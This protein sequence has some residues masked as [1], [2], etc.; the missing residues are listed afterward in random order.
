MTKLFAT[1]NT[2]NPAGLDLGHLCGLASPV[3]ASDHVKHAI[4]RKVG[5]AAILK[6]LMPVYLLT[7]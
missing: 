7:A 4:D 1:G 2:W 6:R 5:K 3:T